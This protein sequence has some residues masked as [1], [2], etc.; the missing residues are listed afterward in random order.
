MRLISLVQKFVSAA[1][2]VYRAG[3]SDKVFAP[4][5]PETRYMSYIFCSDLQICSPLYIYTWVFHRWTIASSQ[6]NSGFPP[7]SSCLSSSSSPSS[8]L[9]CSSGVGYDL[10][11]ILVSSTSA[12]SDPI[13]PTKRITSRAS[14]SHS[15]GW[16]V[17]RLMTGS[18]YL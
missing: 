18:R 3:V 17:S 9:G 1:S 7:S 6:S 15:L 11:T 12:R 14:G 4:R 8:S 2:F 5:N 10:S 16:G 13:T